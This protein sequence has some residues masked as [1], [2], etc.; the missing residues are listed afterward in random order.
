MTAS[1]DSN[2]PLPGN[3]IKL[4]RFQTANF[5][6]KTDF[7]D[8]LVEPRDNVYKIEFTRFKIRDLDTDTVLFEIEK[9]PG[10]KPSYRILVFLEENRSQK[11]AEDASEREDFPP[12][13]EPSAAR[14][15]RYRFTPEFLRLRHV[16]ATVEFVVGNRPVSKFRMLERHFF[17]VRELFGEFCLHSC[18][19]VALTV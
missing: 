10:E 9:P 16:G 11:F 14:Y 2:L 13:P 15:V 18:L 3:L 6:L 12:P 4:D 19:T 17:K 7:S 5:Q 8:Y 1:T